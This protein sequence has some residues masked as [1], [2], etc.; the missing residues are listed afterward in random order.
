MNEVRAVLLV[1]A[2]NFSKWFGE[3][4]VRCTVHSSLRDPESHCCRQHPSVPH[5][6]VVDVLMLCWMPHT[7]QH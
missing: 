3:Q 6:A 4:T 1:L 5:L 2:V 7:G